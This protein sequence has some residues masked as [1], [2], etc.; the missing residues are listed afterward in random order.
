MTRREQKAA[1]KRK[2]QELAEAQRIR[3]A[4]RREQTGIVIGKT[5]TIASVQSKLKPVPNLNAKDEKYRNALN[6]SQSDSIPDPPSKVSTFQHQKPT[7]LDDEPLVFEPDVF[8]AD[9]VETKAVARNVHDKFPLHLTYRE[10]IGIRRDRDLT[11]TENSVY[12]CLR[13]MED[14]DPK[15]FKEGA[16]LMIRMVSHNARLEDV[17]SRRIAALMPKSGGTVPDNCRPPLEPLSG[18]LPMV[19][20]TNVQVVIPA[21]SAPIVPP[22]SPVVSR[23]GNVDGG[24]EWVLV[25]PHNGRGPKT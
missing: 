23:N 16:A 6:T 13:M 19:Q 14:S 21:E 9:V 24:N 18:G 12:V 17:H 11:P 10:L 4:E 20:Q 1:K 5:D 22:S 2:A 3:D 7:V 8:S 15:I 25:I